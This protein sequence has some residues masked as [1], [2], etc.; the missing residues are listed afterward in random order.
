[1]NETGRLRLRILPQ[2]RSSYTSRQSCPSASFTSSAPTLGP[3]EA[4][5]TGLQVELQALRGTD[6]DMRLLDAVEYITSDPAHRV[7]LWTLYWPGSER[8]CH[9][10]R[11]PPPFDD[12]FVGR[13]GSR[14][15]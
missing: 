6:P 9:G 14:L 8:Q 1:V 4:V 10:S 2:P 5:L 15:T 13:Q 11:R 12:R 7:A 3:E